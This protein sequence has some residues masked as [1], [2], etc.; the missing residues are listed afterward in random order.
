MNKDIVTLD[1]NGF[2]V[3]VKGVKV[4]LQSSDVRDL[5]VSGDVYLI[6]CCQFYK[7]GASAQIKKRIAAIQSIIPFDVEIVDSFLSCDVF[8]DEKKLHRLCSEFNVKNEWF[9]L[10][11]SFVKN[12]AK[13]FKPSVSPLPQIMEGMRDFAKWTERSLTPSARLDFFE[14]FKDL[15]YSFEYPKTCFALNIGVNSQL[16]ATRFNIAVKEIYDAYY[17]G[18]YGIDSVQPQSLMLKSLPI[19]ELNMISLTSELILESGNAKD[20]LDL[21]LD[22]LNDLRHLRPNQ[23]KAIAYSPE[24]QT[25]LPVS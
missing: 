14:A 2:Q 13:W 7:I 20:A 15:N 25:E 11:D 21:I 9:L 5:P 18:L 22:I 24:Y 10:P 16:I 3:K 1:R 6:K 23:A 8:Q 17:F 19:Y 4:S 12:R